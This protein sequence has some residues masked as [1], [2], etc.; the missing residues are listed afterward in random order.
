MNTKILTIHARNQM[1]TV[2]EMSKFRY[3]APYDIQTHNPA[4]KLSFIAV[5]IGCALFAI[6]DYLNYSSELL[7]GYIDESMSRS[8]YV[9]IYTI[10]GIVGLVLSYVAFFALAIPL[11]FSSRIWHAIIA[12][13]WW[14]LM[15]AFFVF[16]ILLFFMTMEENNPFL[17]PA[18]ALY[19]VL[20]LLLLWKTIMITSHALRVGKI[21]ATLLS[22]VSMAAYYGA[23]HLGLQQFGITFF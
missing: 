14:S 7:Y 19:W 12:F 21:S 2:W 17:S 3:T 22:I 9:L 11:G 18:I 4:L 6:Y 5:A 15:M 1:R 10:I 16:P 8:T 13:N 20:F 23:M